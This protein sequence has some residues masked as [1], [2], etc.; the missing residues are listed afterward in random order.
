MD[1]DYRRIFGT[2][3]GDASLDKEVSFVDFTSLSFFFDKPGG[4]EQGDFDGSGIVQF[5]DFLMLSS[6]FGKSATAVG[7]VPEPNAAMLFLVGLVGLV[8]RRS[9]V[10]GTRRA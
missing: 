1:L 2:L 8:L 4:W 5:P 7:V 10:S 3:F 9:I 6:N